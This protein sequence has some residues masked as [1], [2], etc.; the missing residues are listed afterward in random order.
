MPGRNRGDNQQNHFPKCKIFCIKSPPAQGHL[1]QPPGAA[2]EQAQ[3]RA[4]SVCLA[5]GRMGVCG[6]CAGCTDRLCPLHTRTCTHTNTRL[7]SCFRLNLDTGASSPKELPDPHPSHA[8][9][10]GVRHDSQ[11]VAPLFQPPS[12]GFHRNTG[13]EGS[14]EVLQSNPCSSRRP[15]TMP[16]RASAPGHGANWS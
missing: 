3:R 15:Y 12:R 5:E 14:S 9:P 16:D 13:L 7:S 11:T 8:I 4:T 10:Q 1:R 6:R 2:T